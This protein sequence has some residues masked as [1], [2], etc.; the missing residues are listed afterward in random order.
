MAQIKQII[1]TVYLF[2]KK[3]WPTTKL[4]IKAIAPIL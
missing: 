4:F 3:A 1:V 2:I